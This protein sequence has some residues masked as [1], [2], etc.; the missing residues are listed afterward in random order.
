MVEL[1]NQRHGILEC[2]HRAREIE[3]FVRQVVHAWGVW[4][5]RRCKGRHFAELLG[6][7]L[8]QGCQHLLLTRALHAWS[9]EA[10]SS[11]TLRVER[12]LAAEKH[13]VE[14]L[15]SELASVSLGR[16]PVI[17]MDA[18]SI[19][20][21]IMKTMKEQDVQDLLDRADAATEAE[22]E[23]E[24]L[25]TDAELV[26]AE[27]NVSVDSPSLWTECNARLSIGKGL[28]DSCPSDNV[29]G[30]LDA[31]V[32]FSLSDTFFADAGS[33]AERTGMNDEKSC[34]DGGAETPH[35]QACLPSCRPIQ[36]PP[37]TG[38]AEELE[39]RVEAMIAELQRPVP[40]RPAAWPG[41]EVSR[42][43]NPCQNEELFDAS[44]IPAISQQLPE[45]TNRAHNATDDHKSRCDS[46]ASTS[47]KSFKAAVFPGR[48]LLRRLAGP[49]SH[50]SRHGL[51]ESSSDSDAG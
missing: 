28:D 46:A 34:A 5:S 9:H 33:C 1:C 3:E 15:S 40:P 30:F 19:G 13:D 41:L 25:P 27:R 36:F 44:P 51:L 2:V 39:S 11:H 26:P 21:H 42:L 17:A 18:A 37:K 31:G 12:R 10:Q 4:S 38:G 8:C 22:A 32:G 48:A 23:A 47:S 20:P 7:R 16:D 6:R 50:A 45:I 24:P 49:K 35:D 29:V 14:R 43:Q